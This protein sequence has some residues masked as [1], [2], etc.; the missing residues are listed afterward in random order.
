MASSTHSERSSRPR[1]SGSRAAAIALVLLLMP[2]AGCLRGAGP[3]VVIVPARLGDHPEPLQ[4]AEGFTVRVFIETS[5]GL[6]V[7]QP[8]HF[9]EGVWI[10]DYDPQPQE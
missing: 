10:L 1:L 5:D 8:E 3:D 9:R 4:A 2:C 7:S 6:V